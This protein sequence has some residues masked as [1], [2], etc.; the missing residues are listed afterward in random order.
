MWAISGSDLGQFLPNILTAPFGRVYPLYLFNFF[1]E[2]SLLPKLMKKKK[3]SDSCSLKLQLE[4][5]SPQHSYTNTFSN[6]S[7][8]T[9]D[10]YQTI[11]Q[12]SPN[13]LHNK[14]VDKRA[15]II[16]LTQRKPYTYKT[17]ANSPAVIIHN[18]FFIL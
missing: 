12:L 17:L 14:G 9:A 8:C 10:E 13:L 16:T 2:C 15:V 7:N 1:L 5:V 11:T 6:F 4:S 18:Y 3:H